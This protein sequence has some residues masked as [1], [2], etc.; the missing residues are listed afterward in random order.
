MV[1]HDEFNKYR[2]RQEPNAI[3]MIHILT[4]EILKEMSSAYS[5]YIE[6]DQIQNAVG[7]FHV[8]AAE[9]IPRTMSTKNPECC[10]HGSYNI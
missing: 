4:A 8:I 7:M 1:E 3:G 10:R 6:P 2:Q 9:F 5:T